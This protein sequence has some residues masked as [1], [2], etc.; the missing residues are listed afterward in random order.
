MLIFG[1]IDIRVH[2]YAQIHLH[3]RYRDETAYANDIA[4]KYV[5]AANQLKSDL[6]FEFKEKVDIEV[7]IRRPV[8]PSNNRFVIP[9][10][11]GDF[12]KILGD[13]QLPNVGS[14]EN[15]VIADKMLSERLFEQCK[16]KKVL[17]QNL[18]RE[19]FTDDGQ[20]N[21][22][23]SKDMVHITNMNTVLKV[24]I[25]LMRLLKEM[26]LKKKKNS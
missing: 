9:K 17:Y 14:I 7:V 21:S 6:S 26:P 4:E 13:D 25:E 1:E 18:Y 20:L 10:S 22:D 12:K 15:R 8:P 19:I 3:R 11:L 16:N 24:H 23:L 5:K 2:S